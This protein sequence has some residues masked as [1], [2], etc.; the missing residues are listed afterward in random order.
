MFASPR[1]MQAPPC[2]PVLIVM[3]SAPCTVGAALTATATI[4]SA[5]RRLVMPRS[6]LQ[7]SQ[8]SQRHYRDLRRDRVRKGI[9]RARPASSVPRRLALAA[10]PA[11]VETKGLCPSIAAQ[12][13]SIPLNHPKSLTTVH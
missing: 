2:K 10:L 9:A 12:T 11:R 5:R 13:S 8:V 1:A 4:A 7:S 6:V 3:A